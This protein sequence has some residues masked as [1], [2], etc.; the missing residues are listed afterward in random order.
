MSQE[1][2]I[3]I[4]A[5]TVLLVITVP[6]VLGL[7][8]IYG[9]QSP[10]EKKVLEEPQDRNVLFRPEEWKKAELAAVPVFNRPLEI[11]APEEHIL[12][13][14]REIQGMNGE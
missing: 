12:P 14:P 2:T 10:V 4:V 3:T 6:V 7:V 11:A 8:A 5:I 9:P 1:F 13:P